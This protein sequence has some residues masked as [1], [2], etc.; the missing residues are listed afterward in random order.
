MV[1]GAGWGPGA[2]SE[3]SFHTTYCSLPSN[4]RATQGGRVTFTS[5]PPAFSSDISPLL[6]GKLQKHRC[7]P[8]GTGGQNGS[9]KDLGGLDP[10][11]N[12]AD[13]RSETKNQ[14]SLSTSCEPGMCSARHIQ[15]T[16]S[17][18]GSGSHPHFAD[19]EPESHRGDVSCQPSFSM[20]LSSELRP[21]YPLCLGHPHLYTLTRFPKSTGTN[22]NSPSSLPTDFCVPI[23]ASLLRN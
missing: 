22:L 23:Q 5:L 2:S 13:R 18:L 20:E 8:M 17:S 1:W 12:G 15:H 11:G 9:C 7:R 10:A 21:G 6:H 19:E 3:S 4:C 16:T 14:H